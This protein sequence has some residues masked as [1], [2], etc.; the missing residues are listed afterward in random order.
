[1]ALLPLPVVSLLPLPV[2]SLLPLAAYAIGVAH[3]VASRVVDGTAPA[4]LGCGG[5]L[6]GCTGCSRTADHRRGPTVVVG[7]S[8]MSEAQ[9]SGRWWPRGPRSGAV[10]RAGAVF[11]CSPGFGT[12]LQGA[13]LWPRGPAGSHRGPTPGTRFRAATDDG[14]A[15]CR[16]RDAGLRRDG[17]IQKQFRSLFAGAA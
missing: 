9:R 11:R 15:S 7:P 6:C 4:R 13:R 3:R 16:P 10:Q 14:A 2:V 1:M 12:G 17:S 8:P 5:L